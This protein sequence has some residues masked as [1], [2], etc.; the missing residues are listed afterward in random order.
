VCSKEVA[1]GCVL[2]RLTEDDRIPGARKGRG[3]E[4][5]KKQRHWA[6]VDSRKM[7]E[8]VLEL[9]VLTTNH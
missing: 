3:K 9:L 1:L 2:E 5:D 8:R 4:A 6:K 7:K